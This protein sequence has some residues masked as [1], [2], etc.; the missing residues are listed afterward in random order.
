VGPSINPANIL[1]HHP[2]KLLNLGGKG[3]KENTNKLNKLGTHTLMNCLQVVVLFPGL[4]YFLQVSMRT[5]YLTVFLQLGLQRNQSP[6]GVCNQP[7]GLLNP[8][9]CIIL[10]TQHCVTLLVLYTLGSLKKINFFEKIWM[11]VTINFL[12]RSE[13]SHAKI[14]PQEWMKTTLAQE[15]L[16]I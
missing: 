2:C 1:H 7:L 3:R 4:L 15:T 13:A 5:S 9:E 6:K 10:V 11:F 14:S 12:K 16:H 8:C